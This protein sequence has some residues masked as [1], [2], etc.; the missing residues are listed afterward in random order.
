MICDD[1]V[2]RYL[3]PA[4]QASQFKEILHL[5]DVTPAREKSDLGLVFND[6]AERF[7]KRGVVVV[8]PTCLMI[9]RGSS[10]GS[11]I[12]ATAGTKSSYFTSSTRPSSISRFAQ[13]R[14]SKA[15]K[16]WPTS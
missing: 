16:A 3:K 7:K 14:S 15:W 8:F 9:P 13:R 4:G 5:L 11:N 2:R 10:P 1:A 6:L 12:F